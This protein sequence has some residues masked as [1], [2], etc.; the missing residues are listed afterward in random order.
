MAHKRVEILIGDVWRDGRTIAQGVTTT[1]DGSGC[2][3]R[4]TLV[5]PHGRACLGLTLWL[6]ARGR[7]VVLYIDQLP[8]RL[9]DV[10]GVLIDARVVNDY[11][12]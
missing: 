6:K 8:M 1:I 12:V 10:D 5:L 9:D 7:K 2:D 3:T 4:A 11:L